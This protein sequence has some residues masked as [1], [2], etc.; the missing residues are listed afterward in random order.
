MIQGGGMTEDMVQKTT[1]ATIENEAKNGL[2]NVKYSLAMART[3]APHSA[4]SQ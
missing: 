4:S 3:M 1:K 2:K